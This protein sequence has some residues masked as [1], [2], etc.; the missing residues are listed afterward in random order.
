MALLDID[1][2]SHFVPARPVLDGVG[3]IVGGLL[4]RREWNATAA[5]SGIVQFRGEG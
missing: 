3:L 4:R 1:R 2:R 5:G